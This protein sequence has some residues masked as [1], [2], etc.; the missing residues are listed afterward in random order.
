MTTIAEGRLVASHIAQL[1]AMRSELS[2]TMSALDKKAKSGASASRRWDRRWA[3][4]RAR[5]RQRYAAVRAHNASERRRYA[6]SETERANSDGELVV[7]RT[8]TPRYWAY[9]SSPK[10]PDPLKVSVATEV[11]R[12]STLQKRIDALE[13][14]IASESPTAQ[15]FESVYESV[16]TATQA[17]GKTVGDATRVAR[18]VVVK[19][20]AKGRVVDASKLGEGGTK[21]RSMTPSAR[22]SRPTWTHFRGRG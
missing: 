9:P 14:T 10:R 15:S 12:L 13:S 16:S 20:G 2:K 11:T 18:T 3:E 1:K 6:A 5:Y 7:V 21:A 19:R 8:Y 22:S 4:R 17:L